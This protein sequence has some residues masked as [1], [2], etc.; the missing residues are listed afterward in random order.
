MSLHSNGVNDGIWPPPVG[1]IADG[2]AEIV[3]MLGEIKNLDAA[4]LGTGETIWNQVD[5]D[6]AMPLM[7][8]DTRSEVP[9]G[10]QSQNHDR[11]TIRNFCV[12]DGLPGRRK[13]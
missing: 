1:Q 8:A 10:S 12:F 9:D 7:G 4:T 13:N 3:L 5:A 11:S 6:D 2:V